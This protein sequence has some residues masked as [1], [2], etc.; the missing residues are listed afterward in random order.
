M[1]ERD[2]AHLQEL[3]ARLGQ[4]AEHLPRSDALTLLILLR[5]PAP[6]KSMVRDLGH[7]VAH[8]SRDQG[9]SFEYLKKFALNVRR[10][11]IHGGNLRVPIMFP[12]GDVIAEMNSVL[13]RLGISGRLPAEDARVRYALAS[14]IADVLDGTTF[15]LDFAR[16]TLR[17]VGDSVGYRAFA[18]QIVYLHDI[19]GAIHIRAEK[20]NALAFPWLMSDREIEATLTEIRAASRP[21]GDAEA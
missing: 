8:D 16:I 4:S 12:I 11:L 14:A 7:S 5:D 6:R 19:E 3:I 21:A 18:A 2:V 13:Q 9:L 17:G 15:K 20:Q 1:R 10:V